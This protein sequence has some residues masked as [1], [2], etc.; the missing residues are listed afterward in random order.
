MHARSNMHASYSAISVSIPPLLSV[1]CSLGTDQPPWTV[2][3]SNVALLKDKTSLSL[4]NVNSIYDMCS[5]DLLSRRRN[6]RSNEEGTAFV[7][8]HNM[9]ILT[10]YW[11]YRYPP[12]R[13]IGLEFAIPTR[14]VEHLVHA[15]VAIMYSN[16]VPSLI[17]PLSSTAPSS[18]MSTLSHVKVIID[19]TSLDLPEAIRDRSLY[20][21]KSSTGNALKYELA[22]DLHYRIISVSRVVHGSIHD[23]TL[24]RQSGILRQL[25]KDSLALGDKS[26]IGEPLIKTPLKSNSK[27][28]KRRM[29][30]RLDDAKEKEPQ[31]ERSAIENINKRVKQWGILSGIY[32]GNWKDVDTVSSIV[33]V[34]TALTNLVMQSHPIHAVK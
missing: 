26:Y 4:E 18:N 20:H 14:T 17:M 8:P 24:A 16:I 12:F 32:R 22:C 34:V 19:S 5:K 10:L 31:R 7:S 27:K 1:L 25:N 28:R 3:S 21:P 11:L 13:S 29:I 33:A 9:L 2:W 6:K 23:L 15:V 30:T